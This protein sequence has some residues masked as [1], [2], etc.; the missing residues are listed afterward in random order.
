MKIHF[1]GT[2]LP[3]RMTV[4]LPAIRSGNREYR[5]YRHIPIRSL[6][7]V[8]IGERWFFGLMAFKGAVHEDC[9]A[10]LHTTEEQEGRK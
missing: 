6:F 10:T 7:G 9:R 2:A 3:S 1:G 4:V 5:S 8:S